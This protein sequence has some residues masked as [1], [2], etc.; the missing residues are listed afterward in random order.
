MHIFCSDGVANSCIGEVLNELADKGYSLDFVRGFMMKCTLPSKYGKAH[1]DWL[2][3]SRVKTHTLTSFAG[4]MLTVV[5]IIFLFLCEFCEDSAD[6]ADIMDI[7]KTLH[8]ICG[9][10]STGPEVPMIHISELRTLI[11]NFHAKFVLLFEKLKPKL[12]HMHHV[13]DAMEWLGK[14]LG[15]FVTERRHRAV[16]DAALHV[17]RYMEH[18]V[19]VD[20]V[21]KHCE[22]IVNG[23]D[24]F[25]HTFLERPSKCKM[26]PDISRSSVAVLPSGRVSSKDVCFFDDMTCGRVLGFFL[27]NAEYFVEVEL[28]NIVDNDPSLRTYAATTTRFIPCRNLVDSCIWHFTSR[29]NIIRVCVPPILLLRRV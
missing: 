29:D 6:L 27:V 28:L 5:P 9:I 21:N 11:S 18:T 13:I 15:C 1:E 8:F 12:H 24:L 2:R 26:Q 14:L 22:Q 17:F 7:V 3:D 23:F 20:I 25:Q 16:K 19:L 4:V 10:L